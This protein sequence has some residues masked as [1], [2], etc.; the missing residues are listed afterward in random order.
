MKLRPFG[1]VKVCKCCGADIGDQYLTYEP[2]KILYV[3][4]GV[5]VYSTECLMVGCVVCG[6]KVATEM[7]VPS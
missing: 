7:R 6:W 1:S 5:E 2:K 4:K 3:H